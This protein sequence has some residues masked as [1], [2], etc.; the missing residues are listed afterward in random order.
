LRELGSLLLDYYIILQG[1]ERLDRLEVPAE[2][3][4]KS[5][6]GLTRHG[7]L[8]GIRERRT[9]TEVEKAQGKAPY[10]CTRPVRV[11]REDFLPLAP[12]ILRPERQTCERERE[13]TCKERRLLLKDPPA[14]AKQEPHAEL[15]HQRHDEHAS[16]SAVSCKVCD[17]Q[18]CRKEARDAEGSEEA[19]VGV[20]K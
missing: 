4:S 5:R 13:L 16:E 17:A 14:I 7:I 19:F 8:E 2:C 1:E 9:L 10:R 18:V 20:P 6:N 3:Q 15:G 11:S 12:Q